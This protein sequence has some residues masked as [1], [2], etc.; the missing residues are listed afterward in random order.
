ML[1]PTIL[2]NQASPV[3]EFRAEMELQAYPMFSCLTNFRPAVGLHL[4]M[5]HLH[6]VAYIT[7]Q[8]LSNVTKNN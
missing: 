6:T 5:G 3:N 7:I 1:Y 4:M 2:S 8:K